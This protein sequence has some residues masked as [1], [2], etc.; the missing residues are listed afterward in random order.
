[1]AD[2]RQMQTI[3]REHHRGV[4]AFGNRATAAGKDEIAR[5]RQRHLPLRPDQRRAAAVGLNPLFHE[6]DG[7]LI[8]IDASGLEAQR[9]ELADHIVGGAVIARRTGPPPLHRIVGQFLHMRPPGRT[10]I[11]LR[12]HRRGQGQRKKRESGKKRAHDGMLLYEP[13]AILP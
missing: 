7:L 6:I 4:D 11:L 8:P 13:G 9:L 2:F 10:V 1:M 5:H 3:A 12:Q